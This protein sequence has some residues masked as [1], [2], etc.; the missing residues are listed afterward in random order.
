MSSASMLRT[1]AWLR[2]FKRLLVRYERRREIHEAVLAIGCGL[3][4]YRR[5]KNSSCESNSQSRGRLG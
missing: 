5:L 1:L 2:H 4:C 3:V